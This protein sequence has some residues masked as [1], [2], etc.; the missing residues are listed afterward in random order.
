MLAVR[1]GVVKAT[2]P[3]QGGSTSDDMEQ[4]R[5]NRHCSSRK[6]KR[7]R[8]EKGGGEEEEEGEGRRRRGRRE[9]ERAA[10]RVNTLHE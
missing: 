4:W 3:V 9:R 8:K 5:V 2:R 10:W 6:K 1:C 7:R